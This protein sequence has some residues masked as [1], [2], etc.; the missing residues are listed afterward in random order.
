MAKKKITKSVTEAKI[1][2]TPLLQFDELVVTQTQTKS[3]RSE[4][5]GDWVD[6]TLVLSDALTPDGPKFH[7]NFMGSDF[8]RLLARLDELRQ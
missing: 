8:G 5:D 6:V 1:I 3:R 7:I 4:D 2:C